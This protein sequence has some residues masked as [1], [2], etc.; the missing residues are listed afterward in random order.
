MSAGAAAG[1]KTAS[2]RLADRVER[3]DRLGRLLV[4]LGRG[5]VAGAL[6]GLLLH[7]VAQGLL[8]L[9]EPGPDAR[10]WAST[11]RALAPAA[12][13]LAGLWVG[14]ARAWRPAP[15]PALA[16]AWALD[17]L[18]GAGERGLAA[19]A[20]PRLEPGA[21][22]AP[23]PP[24]LLP[25][26]GLPLL[27]GGAVLAALTV[28]LPAPA[29]P[30]EHGPQDEAAGRAPADAQAG[31]APGRTGAPPAGP[32]GGLP[33]APGRP[34]DPARVRAESAAAEAAGVRQALGLTAAEGQDAAI[35]AE[36][37]T[38]PRAREQ[39][40]AAAEPGSA[41]AAALAGEAPSAEE[42]ARR[43]EAGERAAE[44]LAAERRAELARWAQRPS[45]YLSPARRALLERYAAAR[46]S[47]RGAAARAGDAPGEAL[48]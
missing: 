26:R 21:P 4:P 10:A 38:D 33:G 36:R 41:L 47:A 17:R 14:L 11:L 40:R 7:G 28:L 35:V 30:P 45:A 2:A 15:V 1:W 8:G 39:A 44:R 37:L 25:P 24:R 6:A 19:A 34:P 31:G 29:P 9:L 42:V 22:Q 18:A 48:R 23:E 27:A 13:A 16:A 32:P 12:G 5:T 43:L 46:A 20:E 3:R